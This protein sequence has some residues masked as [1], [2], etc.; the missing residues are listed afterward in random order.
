MIFFVIRKH[1]HF[2]WYCTNFFCKMSITQFSR[3]YVRADKSARLR[4][5]PEHVESDDPRMRI[6]LIDSLFFFS[7]GYGLKLARNWTW[8]RQ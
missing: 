8:K 3:T 6:K 4:I 2:R 5:L 7:A 1:C